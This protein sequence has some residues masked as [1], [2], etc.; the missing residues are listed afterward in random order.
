MSFTG[1][2]GGSVVKNPPANTGA[3]DSMPG[4]G[5]S[6]GEGNGNPLQHSCLGN[7]MNRE[8]WW[9]AVCEVTEKSDMTEQLN[10]N[11]F[12]SVLKCMH[13]IL[14]IGDPTSLPKGRV[15]LWSCWL[16]LIVAVVSL[17]SRV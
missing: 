10:G 2:H 8:S 3:M 9:A 4:P 5:G 1:F 12:Y 7:S 16:L 17:V 13:L 11:E 15:M 6:P 14:K